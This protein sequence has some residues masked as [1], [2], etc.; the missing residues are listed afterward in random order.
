MIHENEEKTQGG[1]E[2]G[3]AEEEKAIVNQQSLLVAEA[4][5]QTNADCN[6]GDDKQR[7]D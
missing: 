3:D 5:H 4:N 2:T 6:D 1:N 7:Y